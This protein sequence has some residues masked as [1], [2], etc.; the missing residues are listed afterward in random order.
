ML[1]L[2]LALLGNERIGAIPTLPTVRD[3]F[4]AP[5]DLLSPLPEGTSSE[6][7]THAPIMNNIFLDP[8]AVHAAAGDICLYFY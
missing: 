8:Y 6:T 2:I 7:E 5:G 1:R 4:T 3:N